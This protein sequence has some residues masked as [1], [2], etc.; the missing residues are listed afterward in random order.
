[1]YINS[2]KIWAGNNL[3]N[4]VW[5]VLDLIFRNEYM[6]SWL[7]YSTAWPWGC[8]KTT[9]GRAWRSQSIYPIVCPIRTLS[10]PPS[11][12]RFPRHRRI[13]A[14]TPH[15]YWRR[16]D[17]SLTTGYPSRDPF[18]GSNGAF[19][20][21]VAKCK[22]FLMGTNYDKLWRWAQRCRNSLH[23]TLPW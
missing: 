14:R 17:S 21:Y 16:P 20:P 4:L 8:T 11:G 15:G 2:G 5:D 12:R 13:N 7:G 18:T 23:P 1:M 22:C 9:L 3:R 19:S 6:N 10:L